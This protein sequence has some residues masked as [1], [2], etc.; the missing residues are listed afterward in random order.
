MS[1]D[2]D[3]ATAQNVDDCESLDDEEERANKRRK[4]SE[5]VEAVR[6]Q[7]DRLQV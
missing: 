6:V 1:Q 4:L 7:I 2:E 3:M 5:S